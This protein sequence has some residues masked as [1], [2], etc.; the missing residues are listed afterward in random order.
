MSKENLS[1]AD[2]SFKAIADLEDGT[3]QLDH[4]YDIDAKGNYLKGQDGYSL[5][6]SLDYHDLDG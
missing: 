5:S 6:E 3:D 1:E 2:A 4:E